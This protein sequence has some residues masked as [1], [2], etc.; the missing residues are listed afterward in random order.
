MVLPLNLSLLNQPSDLINCCF[1]M[2]QSGVVV[3]EG[4]ISF[5]ANI[6]TNYIN[7]L[8]NT[9]G[10][11]VNVVFP[12]NWNFQT[13]QTF[14]GDSATVEIFI[15]FT[16]P[17]MVFGQTDPDVALLLG[18]RQIFYSS[19]FLTN[20]SNYPPGFTPSNINIEP[21]VIG[22]ASMTINTIDF[23]LNIYAKDINSPS[24]PYKISALANPFRIVTNLSVTDLQNSCFNVNLVNT[25]TFKSLLFCQDQLLVSASC[26]S[27]TGSQINLLP[28]IT[29][30]NGTYR[31]FLL[32]NCQS[33]DLSTITESDLVTPALC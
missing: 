11:T 9:N 2:G 17:K 23:V 4:N 18:Q 1:T 8:T 31:V 26:V 27:P 21:A 12:Y 32:L 10:Q 29:L 5:T 16:S 33:Y 28:S 25:A 13:N 14:V 20:P 22:L 15:P 30:P 19:L 24:T 7:R 3:S 6:T